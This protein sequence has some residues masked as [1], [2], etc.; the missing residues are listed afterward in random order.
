MLLTIIEVKRHIGSMLEFTW[1]E[2][3]KSM[4]LSD[5]RLQE[6]IYLD[7]PVDIRLKVRNG[8]DRLIFDGDVSF[9]LKMLCGRCLVEFTKEE[10]FSFDDQMLFMRRAA[11]AVAGQN[12]SD[13]EEDRGFAVLEGDT[14]DATAMVYDALL[15]YLPM[16]PLCT[17]DCLGLCPECGADLNYESCS[18]T[19]DEIDPRFAALAS[20]VIK[21]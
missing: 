10:R 3:A 1:Q 2:D 19:S 20:W 13:D 8:G 15:A 21:E 6:D 16:K 5:S 7:S 14:V 4:A 12:D 11:A 9:T 18:C 17:E